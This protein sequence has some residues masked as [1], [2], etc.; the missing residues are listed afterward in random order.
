MITQ[1][2]IHSS[3]KLKAIICSSSLNTFVHILILRKFYYNLIQVSIYK[4]SLNCIY[5]SNVS[6]TDLARR[7]KIPMKLIPNEELAETASRIMHQARKNPY[8]ENDQFLIPESPV[9]LW[10]RKQPYHK[11]TLMHKYS[12]RFPVMGKGRD[13]KCMKKFLEQSKISGFQDPKL[14]TLRN[15]LPAGAPLIDFLAA[16]MQRSDDWKIPSRGEIEEYR[17][18]R[19]LSM[20]MLEQV[21]VKEIVPGVTGKSEEKEILDWF[22]DRY[23]E[24]QADLPTH[25]VSMDVEQLQTTLYDTYRMAG[26]LKFKPGRVI[27]T[28]LERTIDEEPDDRPQQLPVKIM[29]GNGI[30][31]ALMISLDINQNVK[32]Q[33]LISRFNIPDTIVKFLAMLPVCT[34]VGVRHD[35]SSI[36]YFYSLFSNSE[37]IMKGF[38]ELGTLATLAGYKMESKCMTTLALQVLGMTM[39]KMVSTADNRWGDRWTEIPDAL[40]VY[41]LGDLRM[42]HMTYSIL[43]AVIIRDYWPDPDIVLMYFNTFNQWEPINWL[44]KLLMASLEGAELHEMDMKNAGSRTD[45]I[46]CIRYKLGEDAP[47]ADEPPKRVKIWARMKGSWPSLTKGSCR[48][49]LQ[50]RSWFI[51][52]TSIWENEK[53]TGPDGERMKRATDK[54]RLYARFGINSSSIAA[55]SFLE[56]SPDKPGLQRPTSLRIPSLEMNPETTKCYTIGKFCGKQT[57]IQRMI[58]LEW[59][60]LNPTQIADFLR[61]LGSDSQYQKFYRHL[62]D[63]LRHMFRRLYAQEALTV[64]FMDGLLT[65]T[66]KNKRDEEFEIYE[67]V[68][69]EEEIRARRIIYMDKLLESGDDTERAKWVEEIP[70]LPKWVILKQKRKERGSKRTASGEQ[71]S[72][73][74]KKA[75]I[76]VAAPV[77]PEPVAAPV[78]PEPVAAPVELEPVA[79]PVEVLPIHVVNSDRDSSE[80]GGDV[81]MLLDV[82][83]DDDQVPGPSGVEMN[84]IVIEREI[85]PVEV[86]TRQVRRVSPGP[87]SVQDELNA[88]RP[89]SVRKI[90]MRRPKKGKKKKKSAPKMSYDEMIESEVQK[91]SDSEFMLE[92]QFDEILDYSP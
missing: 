12:G 30:S 16:H 67:R 59:A 61:R 86:E 23:Y 34:G 88:I 60:R 58:I 11:A 89:R 55:S 36:E 69:R 9:P 15:L 80:D 70:E 25:T 82:D 44:L 22:W 65:E 91:F 2:M 20:L 50:A 68:V 47:L 35:V 66:I 37:L 76:Q 8:V 53:L 75:K 33:N 84:R 85:T 52:M 38:V 31:Y 74:S 27:T 6:E 1:I 73:K 29:I 48:F 5:F 92:T 39:N 79:A 4:K 40:K 10:S 63:P 3:S 13:E 81:V 42:G 57:R 90:P 7:L 43:S 77:E 41:G 54:V 72:S 26:R 78:E 51:E 45:L 83:D 14:D 87:D 28:E 24:D 18:N 71:K 62:Y 17:K 19:G 32:G 56:P 46:N 21:Q 64:V 49:L